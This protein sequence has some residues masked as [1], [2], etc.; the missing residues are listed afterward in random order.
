[1]GPTNEVL[2]CPKAPYTKS[3]LACRP[4]L[5]YQVER[6][7]T[8]NEAGSANVQTE[9]ESYAQQP[10]DGQI[11]EIKG[12]SV[13]YPGKGWFSESVVA[14]N[15]V[16]LS[17]E[18]GKTLGLVGESGSGKSSLAKVIIGLAPVTNGQV[19]FD[20]KELE[21]KSHLSPEM[22]RRIQYI[23]QDSYGALNPRHK[24]AR[25]IGEPLDIHGLALGKERRPTL[26]R[27]LEE[28]GLE[29]RHL[30]RYP[31]ELSGGQRQRVNIARA[32]ALNPELLICDEIVSALDV[33]VQAQIL[34]LLK[35]IQER[36]HLSLLFIS[37]DLAV[38]RFMADH[39]A[40]MLEGAIV[41]LDETDV[42]IDY[43]SNP[44]T[45]DLI[46]AVREIEPVEL[47][48]VFA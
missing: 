3:L 2:T 46:A 11:L 26:E 35:D 14:V 6:L 42:I 37:H 43:P 32:L 9:L 28:V 48:P 31:Q 39:I 22:Y 41:E 36:H 16:S 23:F 10:Q 27:L 4:P 21:V 45:Q 38:V 5:D 29:R 12:L 24:V 47:E 44:Y 30:D 25:L 7:V 15:N 13:V 34:N 19:L 8:L 17:L 20:G 18:R 40:V 33:S 1:M